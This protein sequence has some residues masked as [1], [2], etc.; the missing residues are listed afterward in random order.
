MADSTTNEAFGLYAADDSGELL[1]V[2]V[3]QGFRT[4]FQFVCDGSAEGFAFVMHSGDPNKKGYP[5]FNLGYAGQCPHH[6]RL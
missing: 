3:L 2:K 6:H 1:Q 5:G 4:R